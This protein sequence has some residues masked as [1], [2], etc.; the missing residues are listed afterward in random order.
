MES[1]PG[2]DAWL[3]TQPEP[4]CLPVR[5]T[6]CGETCDGDDAE[7]SGWYVSNRDTD[8]CVLGTCP[9]CQEEEEEEDE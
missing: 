4:P 6:V 2:Y 7:R 9:V 3:T 8:E 5:C 1:L